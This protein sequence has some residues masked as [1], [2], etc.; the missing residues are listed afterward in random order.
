VLSL[1]SRRLEGREGACVDLLPEK[2]DELG[3]FGSERLSQAPRRPTVDGVGVGVG[4]GGVMGL[5]SRGPL[6]VRVMGTRR[7]FV[8]R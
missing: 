4:D 2:V 8:C 7:S 6:K 5:E 1:N 3:V